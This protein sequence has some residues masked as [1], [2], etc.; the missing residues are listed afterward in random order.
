MSKQ[1]KQRYYSIRSYLSYLRAYKARLFVTGLLFLV[2]NILLAII[3]IFVGKLVGA[4]AADPVQGH[5]AIIYV[6]IL[7]GC[8]TGH[9]WLWRCS[10]VSYM[11]LVHP[12]PYRYENILFERVIRKPYPY[13]VD[14]FTG[15][16]SS[17]IT[18]LTQ[19]LN[20]FTDS[21]F[22][23][24]INQ[25]VSMVTIV[26]ILTSIN[27]Q[28]GA[29]FLAGITG[30][31]IVG[32]LTIRNSSRYEKLASDVQS[33]KNGKLIDAIA[34]FVN[35]KSFQKESDEIR[36]IKAEQE[37]MVRSAVTSFKWAIGFWG[38]VSIFVR[39]FIWPT[40]IGINVYLFLHGQLTIA[41]LATLIS[42]ILLFSNMIWE[43]VW[44]TSQLNL[45]LARTEE[46]HRYLFGQV[47]I[48]KQQLEAAPQ[49][50][51]KI[52]FESELDLKDLSFAYPD[53]KDTPVLR[54]INLKLKKGEK[55][56]IVGRSG[57]G[58]TTLTKLLLNYY[59]IESGA[60]TIDGAH[61][62]AH[63][64]S[65]L[66]SYVPQDTSLF[67]RTIAENIAYATDTEASR[68]DIV[69]A[70]KKAHAHEFIAQIHDGYEALVGERGVKLS[71]GQ[72]QRI[73]IARAFLDD[74]P[75]LVL[76]EATSALDSESEI[77]VQEGLEALWEH[78]T[79]L[80]IAHRLSTLRHMDRIIV[81]E[82]GQIIEEGTHTELLKQKGTYAK[83]WNHQSGGFIED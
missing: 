31:I 51:Q 59:E 75:I 54:S 73:A 41:Q 45:K 72:R 34:N 71:A 42:T 26:F 77:L 70:A 46:A 22:F 35:V 20:N 78:K 28:T 29:L 3:P 62:D 44:H 24:Y 25:I 14:K 47:N 21:I 58:K 30:M 33:T 69:E 52:T 23:N 32:R 81:M 7:I 9:N 17:Y 13:F 80:A 55:L 82:K 16:I 8:S 38:S 36:T 2:A 79:V 37:K 60:I 57:S 66:V 27:W 50:S 48:T 40:T 18:S 61:I 53:K 15:K 19:E 12:L 1:P 6:W 5:Q 76:D 74:K 11:L 56:G 68:E 67:H 39:D 10:E 43:I 83:L 65:S 4:L 64:L 49:P 63:S